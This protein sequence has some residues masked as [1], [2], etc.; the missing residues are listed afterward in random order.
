MFTIPV[1]LQSALGYSAFES[2][3]ALV[4]FSLATLVLAVVSTSWRKYFAQKHIVQVGLVLI[5]LGILLLVQRTAIDMTLS[6]M[7]LPMLIIGVGLGLFTGQLVDLTMSAVSESYSSV[8]SGVINSMSQ[9]GY[10]FGTGVAGSLLLS[11]FYASVVEGVN[12]LSSGTTLSSSDR[13]QL[14]VKLEDAL[15]TTT[16]AQQQAFVS[17]LSPQTQQQLQEVFNTSMVVAQKGVLMLL[18]LF[19]LVTIFAASFLPLVKPRKGE[20]EET[21]PTS[22]EQAPTGD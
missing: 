22:Q 12:Q 2:G 4:P 14:A 18:V 20:A 9:L 19:V 7:V 1:F 15:E 21:P 13:S 3:V 6:D 5:G 11:G 17:S 16:Q 10:A 8:S